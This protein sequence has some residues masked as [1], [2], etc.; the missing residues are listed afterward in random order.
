MKSFCTVRLTNPVETLSQGSYSSGRNL[1]PG[2]SEYG[3]EVN[4]IPQPPCRYLSHTSI[5]SL[6]VK[7]PALHATC[8]VRCYSVRHKRCSPMMSHLAKL[9]EE[10]GQEMWRLNKDWWR[11]SGWVD[12]GSNEVCKS[13]GRWGRLSD[14]LCAVY[15]D[16][17][18]TRTLLHCCITNQTKTK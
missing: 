17:C 9:T 15:R 2:P 14:L 6:Q 8:A 13:E 1:K 12:I 5:P 11:G 7:Y 4:I 18:F 10:V 3:S 16:I